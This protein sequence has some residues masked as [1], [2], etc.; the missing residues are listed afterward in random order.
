MAN[1]TVLAQ[2]ELNARIA[3]ATMLQRASK[4]SQNGANAQGQAVYEYL[5]AHGHIDSNNPL[6][7][8][9]NPKYPTDAVWTNCAIR[10]KATLAADG[11]FIA[12]VGRKPTRYFLRELP[13]VTAK[14]T[15]N[16]APETI[17]ST[18][19]TETTQPVESV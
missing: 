9:L 11:Y 14:Q 6:L 15:V 7:A 3:E 10:M 1:G 19:S 2:D 17:E 4:G 5:K 13:S 16:V 12:A 18:E 8:Q